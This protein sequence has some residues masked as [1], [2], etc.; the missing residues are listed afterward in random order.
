SFGDQHWPLFPTP[1]SYTAPHAAHHP[2][3]AASAPETEPL[4]DQPEDE[5]WSP[6]FSAAT[7]SSNGPNTPFRLSAA[8]S[9]DHTPADS[10]A[11]DDITQRLRSLGHA[12]GSSEEEEEDSRSG[13]QRGSSP[14]RP[15]PGCKGYALPHSGMQSVQS[16]GKVSSLRDEEVGARGFGVPALVLQ[17]TEGSMVEDLFSEL[18]YLGTC[19]T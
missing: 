15:S 16:L 8:D 19:I 17:P 9:R 11:L 14:W 12:H 6:S 5:L 18:G 13:I 2:D 3:L 10:Y 7:A 1:P 4:H